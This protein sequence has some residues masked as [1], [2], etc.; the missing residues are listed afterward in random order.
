MT[1]R[2]SFVLCTALVLAAPASAALLDRLEVAHRGDA[3]A[4]ATDAIDV[5]FSQS[6]RRDVPSERANALRRQLASQ[7]AFSKS[8]AARSAA[9]I[10]EDLEANGVASH[11]VPWVTIDHDTTPAEHWRLIWTPYGAAMPVT[12]HPGPGPRPLGGGAGPVYVQYRIELFAPR[13]AD[14]RFV[15]FGSLKPLAESTDDL[16]ALCVELFRALADG[17]YVRFAAAPAAAAPRD[18]SAEERK[19]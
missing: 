7:G 9:R 14:P 11:A 19:L 8:F 4:T 15:A 12:R 1:R 18:Y 13:E 16:D 17:R 3:P 10:V 2:R 5:M 6:L